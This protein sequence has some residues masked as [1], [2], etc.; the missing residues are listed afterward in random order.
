MDYYNWDIRLRLLLKTKE[1][2]LMDR[3]HESY[4][5]HE[6][7]RD[8]QTCHPSQPKMEVS[9]SPIGQRATWPIK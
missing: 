3:Y 4:K 8:S 7:R 1:A 2:V 9:P 6:K 5:K